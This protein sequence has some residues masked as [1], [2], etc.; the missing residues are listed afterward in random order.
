MPYTTAAK[1]VMLDAID[2]GTA[3]SL[4]I[5]HVGAF[6]ADAGK[7]LTTPF[8]VASTDTFTCTAHGYSNGDLVLLSGLTG[9]TGLVAGR[10]YFVI[11]ST[12]NTFQ[13]ALTVG[14]SAVDFTSDVTA[15]TVTRLVEISGGSPAYARKAIAYAAAAS[16][17]SDDSTNGAVIDVPA[18]TVSHLGMF[19]AVTAG[20]L[21]A[22]GSVTP[23]V[24]AAQGTYTVTDAK[25]D[26]MAT[27]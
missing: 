2:R 5:S 4:S 11:G 8:G 23:E 22:F 15:G 14:G 20:T 6:Q 18:C 12:A 9:G 19:S 21:L 13:L 10:A 7:A 26:L 3:P 27:A 24:F 16:G 17:I 25:L 1:N